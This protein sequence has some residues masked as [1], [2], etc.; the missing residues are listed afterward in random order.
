MH[1]EPPCRGKT[2]GLANVDN[3]K[4]GETDRTNADIHKQNI[5]QMDVRP[6]FNSSF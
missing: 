4:H 6:I 1:K 5:A 2:G 3:T